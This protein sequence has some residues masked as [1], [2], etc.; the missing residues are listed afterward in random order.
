MKIDPNI[1]G[2]DFQT[3]YSDSYVWYKK[4]LCYMGYIQD[5]VIYDLSYVDSPGVYRRIEDQ[6]RLSLISIDKP[7]P[8]YF[9]HQQR[10]Y[11]ANYYSIRGH[12]NGLRPNNIKILGAMVLADPRYRKCVEAFLFND[13]VPSCC[14][15]HKEAEIISNEVGFVLLSPQL[16]Y[17]KGRIFHG[18]TT[19]YPNPHVSVG[20]LRTYI[21]DLPEV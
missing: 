6:K 13:T 1:S 9:I 3:Q 19:M 7:Q 2:E 10:P 11:Y 21:S 14:L 17:T 5:R 15:T 12:V 20:F 18:E 8:H 16:L 4:R